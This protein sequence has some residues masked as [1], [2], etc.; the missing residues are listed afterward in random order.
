VLPNQAA[1]GG[2]VTSGLCSMVKVLSSSPL[3]PFSFFY[4]VTTP[5]FKHK[6]EREIVRNARFKNRFSPDSPQRTIEKVKKIWVKI[7]KIEI[8]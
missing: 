2:S 8:L 4:L 5:L 1:T 7:E 3:P 6:L